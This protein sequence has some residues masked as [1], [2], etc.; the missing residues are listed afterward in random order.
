MEYESLQTY[1]QWKDVHWMKLRHMGWYWET[2]MELISA[3]KKD[4]ISS[5]S[6]TLVVRTEQVEGVFVMD[7]EGTFP[8]ESKGILY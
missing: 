7:V 8:G 6:A 3:L 5:S 4:A 1:E 2:R